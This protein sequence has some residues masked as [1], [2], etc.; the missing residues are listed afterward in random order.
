MAPPHSS[1]RGEVRKERRAWE[2]AS[3]R[4]RHGQ[5]RARAARPWAV[6]THASRH[7]VA[8]DHLCS[9]SRASRLTST[10]PMPRPPPVTTQERPHP[11]P[12]RDR[13][14]GHRRTAPHPIR[15]CARRTHLSYLLN[16][17][18]VSRVGQPPWPHRSPWS[19]RPHWTP[20][21]ASQCIRRIYAQAV[22]AGLPRSVTIRK[23][24]L[25][26]RQIRPN[27]RDARW[28]VRKV[29]ACSAPRAKITSAGRWRGRRSG[30]AALVFGA[31]KAGGG[32]H[33]VAAM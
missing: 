32:H 20:P 28:A 21:A 25:R 14:L 3:R 22:T 6:L 17:A 30:T 18:P 5:E 24:R 15:A 9:G 27:L 33:A 13:N 8:R 26:F 1:G 10:R 2:P 31:R 16:R 4:P 11:P 19:G 29:N 12:G 7:Q 23:L